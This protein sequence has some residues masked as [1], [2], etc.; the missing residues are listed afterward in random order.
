MPLTGQTRMSRGS[1]AGSCLGRYRPPLVRSPRLLRPGLAAKDSPSVSSADRCS[2]LVRASLH[3]RTC[4]GPCSAALVECRLLAKCRRAQV[5]TPSREEGEQ[6]GAVDRHDHQSPS[7]PSIDRDP[8][9]C[10]MC[11]I[12]DIKKCAHLTRT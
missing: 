7:S 10:A 11:I 12:R 8:A 9:R 2:R 1:E 4:T 3:N 6:C 5:A